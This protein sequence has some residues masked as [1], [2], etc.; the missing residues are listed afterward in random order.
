MHLLW[1]QK[2]TNSRANQ[3]QKS[4]IFYKILQ[5][6]SNE[7]LSLWYEPTLHGELCRGKSRIWQYKKTKFGYILALFWSDRYPSGRRGAPRYKNKK[8]FTQ[9]SQEVMKQPKLLQKIQFLIIHFWGRRGY[10]GKMSTKSYSVRRPT[11]TCL[12]A[13]FWVQTIL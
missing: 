1:W 5:S 12:Y 7:N 13:G 6:P 10:A 8:K 11:F 2:W 9:I 4:N 3:F